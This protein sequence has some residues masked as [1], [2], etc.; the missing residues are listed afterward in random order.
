MDLLKQA[1]N[2]ITSAAGWEPASPDSDGVYHFLV[3]DDLEMDFFS[4][5]GRSG[6][7][8]S[9][10]ARVPPDDPSATDLLKVCAQRAVAVCKKRKSVLAIQDDQL[11]LHYVVKLQGASSEDLSRLATQGAKDF[12]NDLAWWK[13]QLD[14]RAPVPSASV[15]NL[16]ALG[17]AWSSK[18]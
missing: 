2:T 4:P 18:L 7:F 9:T 14:T 11:A 6:I 16:A 1:V 5:D 15:F 13:A 17:T 8:K 12:L 3:D 10:L